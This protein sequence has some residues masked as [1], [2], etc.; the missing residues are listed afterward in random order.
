MKFGLQ[1]FPDVSPDEKSAM[2]YWQECLDL[3]ALADELG[4]AH[5]RTVEH[6]FHPYGGYS[7]NPLVFL[8]AAAQRTK[9]VRLITGALLPI[10]NSPH[11]MAGEIGMVDAISRGRLDVGFARAFLPHEFAR[12]NRDMDESRA[13]FDEGLEQ[14]RRL[15][16]E[17]DV[18]LEGEFHTLRGVTSLPRPTQTPRPPFLLAASSGD[19][20]F[21][22]A[23]QEGHGVM[24]IPRRPDQLREWISAYRTAWADAGHPPGKSRAVYGTHMYCAADGDVARREARPHLEG[25]FGRLADATK[26]WSEVTSTAYPNHPQMMK[27]TRAISVD[28]LIEGNGL[29][30]GSPAEITDKVAAYSDA[31]GGFDEASLQVNFHVLGVEQ[32]EASI[33]LFAEQVMPK[34]AT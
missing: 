6:Y 10:F 27:E 4:Y 34:F 9:N 31:V 23:G 21:I 17:E 18:T 25:Y 28:Q 22:K 29:W 19:T 24:F 1:F 13:R 12:L 8:S 16:E 33:R 2:Q 7:A 14:V 5:V 15:L 20:T 32:A 30:V 26:E 3:A 11:K